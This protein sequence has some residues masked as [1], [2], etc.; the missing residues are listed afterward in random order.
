M[1]STPRRNPTQRKLSS[2]SA[3]PPLA[4][5]SLIPARRSFETQWIMWLGA[6]RLPRGSGW[7][8]GI[9]LRRIRSSRCRGLKSRCSFSI[10]PSAL[11]IAW[12]KNRSARRDSDGWWLESDNLREEI[13]K[14]LSR[15]KKGIW[16]SRRRRSL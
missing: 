8:G 13:S 10:A 12:S 2:S 16:F 14:S 7:L 3:P 6:L 11:C 4:R 1:L 9:R 5:A 15:T